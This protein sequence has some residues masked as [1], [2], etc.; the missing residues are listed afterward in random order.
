[1]AR[2]TWLETVSRDNLDE[3]SGNQGKNG[4]IAEPYDDCRRHPWAQAVFALGLTRG[5]TP[6]LS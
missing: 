5:V 4:R 6:M 1:L 2:E 3:E